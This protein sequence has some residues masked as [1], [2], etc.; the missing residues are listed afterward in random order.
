[1]PNTRTVCLIIIGMLLAICA[2]SAAEDA[3]IAA[4]S[5]SFQHDK[6]TLSPGEL[7]N[8][9]LLLL[10]EVN[11]TPGEFV[12]MG[13]ENVS[14]NNLTPLGA[15]HA[16]AEQGVLTYHA[17]EY[18]Y[19]NG[20]PFYAVN[21][22][23]DIADNSSAFPPIYWG[24]GNSTMISDDF[25]NFRLTDGDRIAVM[26]YPYMETFNESMVEA[27]VGITVHIA[28][29]PD[30]DAPNATASFTADTTMGNAPFTVQFADTSTILDITGWG[31][32]F[33]N[34]F[35]AFTQNPRFTYHEPGTYTVELIVTDES[36]TAYRMVAED[37]IRVL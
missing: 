10:T 22:I 6:L 9:S 14:V 24:W 28:G 33:G 11:L 19:E 31:W 17:G 12:P 25:S 4:R 1:M 27:W 2:V 29:Q 3:G 26:Y 15:V 36:G 30:I 7:A 5:L 21:R 13:L 18:A 32:N 34:G 20:T 35:T 37:Y 8:E 16:A 23:N